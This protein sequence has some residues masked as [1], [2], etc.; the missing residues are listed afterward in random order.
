MYV[1][2]DSTIATKVMMATLIVT[3]CFTFLQ[4]LYSG[5]RPYWTTNSVSSSNCLES[6]NH[7][8]IGFALLVF[9]P[10]YS[11]Y[12]WRQRFKDSVHSYHNKCNIFGIIAVVFAIMLV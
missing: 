7:P 12:C 4:L 8:D 10:A 1:A 5:G 2:L 6:F 3:Q 9:I 11:Y